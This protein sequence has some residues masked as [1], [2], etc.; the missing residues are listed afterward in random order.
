MIELHGW[1]VVR[2]DQEEDILPPQVLT[3]LRERLSAVGENP[4][5]VLRVTNGL[6]RVTVDGYT[7]HRNE[8]V[9]AVLDLMNWIAASTPFSYGLLYLKDDEG[10]TDPERFLVH[11]LARGAVSIAEDS[12]LSPRFPVLDAE[13]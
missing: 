5:A 1:F 11:V 8:G 13:Y 9:I 10:A 3:A 2:M 6:Y 7:N 12:L 4:W